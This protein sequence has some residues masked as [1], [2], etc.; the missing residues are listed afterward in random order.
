MMSAILDI[1]DLVSERG[2]IGVEELIKQLSH[3]RSN[4]LRR[5]LIELRARDY[6]TIKYVDGKEIVCK[7]AKLR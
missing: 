7:G 4:T 2:E 3:W 5:H 1:L 6:I